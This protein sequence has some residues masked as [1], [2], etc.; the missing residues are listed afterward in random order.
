MHLLDDEPR[1]VRYRREVREGKSEVGTS[2]GATVPIVKCGDKEDRH[3]LDVKKERVR[4][5]ENNEQWKGDVVVIAQLK[6]KEKRDAWTRMRSVTPRTY[7]P[8]PS[9]PSSYDPLSPSII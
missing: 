9:L 5:R 8:F 3:G 1:R 4:R 6:A 2:C 7:T